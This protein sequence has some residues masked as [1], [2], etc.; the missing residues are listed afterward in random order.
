MNEHVLLVYPH[1]DDE[2][3]FCSGTVMGLIEKGIPVTYVCLTLGEMGRGLGG[4]NRHTLPQLRHREFKNSCEIIGIQDVRLWGYLDKTIEFEDPEP[5][6]QRLLELAEEIQPT[7][8]FTFYP[9]KSVHPDH[10]ATGSLVVEAMR[11][12]PK[13]RRP[14][15]HGSAVFRLNNVK[16]KEPDVIN[17]ITPYIDRKIACIKAY[18]SQFAKYI[19]KIDEG[20]L[21][22]L[23]NF[24]EGRF[25]VLE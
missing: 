25:W 10:D 15:V 12:L 3:F 22:E 18:P 1:P 5:I 14:V 19:K 11:R 6:I 7:C 24:R 17:D 23:P 2:V 16:V 4:A 13:E 8:V 21:T 20:D 9:G